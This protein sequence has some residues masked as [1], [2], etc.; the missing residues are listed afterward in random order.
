M[1][2]LTHRKVLVVVSGYLE[3]LEAMNRHTN[4]ALLAEGQLMKLCGPHK[5]ACCG[6][7]SSFKAQTNYHTLFNG[8][9]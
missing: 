1:Q 9:Q 6:S 3:M 7:D 8:S 4:I 2:R 5:V